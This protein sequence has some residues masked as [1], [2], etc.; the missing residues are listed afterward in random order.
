MQ[1]YFS[2]IRQRKHN[3]QAGVG[4]GG[5][6]LHIFTKRCEVF[7][8]ESSSGCELQESLRFRRLKCKCEDSVSGRKTAALDDLSRRVA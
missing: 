5:A 6:H 2:V 3:L 4:V 1:K 7:G 8:L